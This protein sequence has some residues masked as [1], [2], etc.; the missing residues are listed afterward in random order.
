MQTLGRYEII[1]PLGAGAMGA[2]YKARDP[3][4]DR[5][6][7]VKTILAH[8]A[9]G[10]Q[11]ADYRE[12]FFR[13]ARAAGRLSHPGIVAMY[14]V[15]EHEGTPFLV[16]EYVAGR[17]LQ[18]S[19]EAGE[20]YDTERVCDVGIQIAEA[21]SYAHRNGVIHRDIKPANILI[22]TENQAKIADFGVAKLA[23]AQM[24]STGQLLGTPAFMAPEQFT[25][26][27]IDGRADLFA[28]GVV[29]YW[30]ATGDKPFTGDTLMAVS[31]KVVHT[32]PIPPR[33]LNPGVPR[34]LE[35]VILKCMEKDPAQRYQNGEALARDLRALRE[36]RPLAT[37]L[38]ATDASGFDSAET[39]GA[40]PAR[41]GSAPAISGSANRAVA[42]GNVPPAKQVAVPGTVAAPPATIAAPP[43]AAHKGSKFKWIMIVVIVT[44]VIGGLKDI[45]KML[46]Q[47][48]TPQQP[49][50]QQTTPAESSAAGPQS[51]APAP[52]AGAPPAPI[53]DAKAITDTVNSALETAKAAKNLSGSGP[54]LLSP[55]A[56]ATKGGK[57]AAKSVSLEIIATARATVV[58]RAEGQPTGSFS[59]KP[60]ESIK[61]QAEK[62]ATLFTDNPAAL[63]VKLNGKK[64]SLGDQ[65]RGRQ[66][67]ITPSGI[68]EKRSQEPWAD[69]ERRMREYGG[70]FPGPPASP[71]SGFDA[72]PRGANA[73]GS[74]A[75]QRELAQQPDSAR[76]FITCAAVP[77]FV[78]IVIQVDN[79]LLLRRD[80][81]T[82][83]LAR[84]GSG[85]VVL[86]SLEMTPLAE[87]R[88]L[89][90][91]AHQFRVVVAGG[92]GRRMNAM[93][94]ISGEFKAGQRRTLRIE[95]HADA[96]GAARD[97]NTH[98]LG[99]TLE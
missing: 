94:E 79:E 69:F 36:E 72:G 73:M 47:Q 68:D 48:K 45:T 27:P 95:L 25:G 56:T 77:E 70:R 50:P 17:T 18:S 88:A 11:A 87:E 37:L 2:V 29:L 20:R 40:V 74:P 57:V 21:L 80:A 23:S 85:K 78:T 35:A 58:F 65:N 71:Q 28:A 62:E 99:V 19:L 63:Q 7:A 66:V 59:M 86:R 76:V 8:A 31:Y 53:L 98:R 14:D 34:E 32:E 26:A 5:V 16:M 75:R 3:M 60:G 89:P 52:A 64:I 67:V 39:V 82:S 44:I 61:L 96:A 12:R 46:L 49:A 42:S 4:M 51:A 81:T 41:A 1:E 30:M 83:A 84:D 90:A 15:A 97:G 92:G 24:T 54:S 22:T 55:A 43:P 6:V 9:A 38:S 91:G 13:E 93:Q 10:P 33:K